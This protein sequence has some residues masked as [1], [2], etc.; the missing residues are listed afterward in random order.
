MPSASGFLVEREVQTLQKLLKNPP[1]P[2]V[3]ILGGAKVSDKIDVLTNLSE[4]TDVIYIGGGMAY[5]FLKAQ[6]R[7]IGKSILDAEKVDFARSL[8]QSSAKVHI[9]VDHVVSDQLEA[10]GQ[11][12]K[13]QGAD[14]QDGWLGVDIGPKSVA[15]LEK[16]LSQAKTIFWNGPLGVFENPEFSQGTLACAQFVAKATRNGAFSVVGGGDSVSALKKS[17][18]DKDVSHISTGGGASLEFLEGKA[19]P[20]INVLPEA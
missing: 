1:K 7:L 18:C 4:K 10:G 20:G 9:P 16:V 19:L 11:V 15:E 8:L 14:I 17:G 2:F 5:T 3:A 13:T 12:Q 6:G